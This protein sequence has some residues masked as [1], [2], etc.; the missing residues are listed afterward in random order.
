M[1]K[2]DRMLAVRELHLTYASYLKELQTLKLELQEY[3]TKCKCKDICYDTSLKMAMFSP[4]GTC[5]MWNGN[6]QG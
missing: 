6:W 4:K 1:K 2:E 3:C 5:L